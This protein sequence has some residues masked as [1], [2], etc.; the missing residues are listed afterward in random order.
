MFATLVAS[1][2]VRTM[3]LGDVSVSAVVHSVVISLA[4]VASANVAP[5]AE[6]AQGERLVFAQPEVRE[7]KPA[8]E[9]PAPA[10]VDVVVAAPPAKGFQVLTAPITVPTELP[11]IDLA[12]AV[13]NE[14]DFSGR[15]VEG[16]V[17][18]GV[19]GGRIVTDRPSEQP[20]FEF[21]VE[22]A[23][24]SAGGCSPRYPEALRAASIE[25]EV[26][27]QFVVDAA[28]RAEPATFK[29]LK[30]A[31]ELFTASV[32]DCLPGMRFLPAEVG[33][34]KVKQLVQQP[35]QFVLQR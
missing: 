1:R 31:H 33:G 34:R 28:G 7:E 9:P 12:R 8:P 14:A 17:A 15:G 4:V 26:L 35:F 18:R 2:P 29:V 6:R 22:K 11:P 13:T 10:V 25:G 3:R 21:Q 23:V 16:G 24:V 30:S 32:K 20:Y 27:A 19:E 5:V